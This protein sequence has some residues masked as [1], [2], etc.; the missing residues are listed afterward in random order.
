MSSRKETKVL[1]EG[2]RRF[3]NE[4]EEANQVVRIFDFDG[5]IFTP[6]DKF[7]LIKN[8]F[9]MGALKKDGINKLFTVVGSALG[10]SSRNPEY[11]SL[12]PSTDYIVSAVKSFGDK[13]FNAQYWHDLLINRN[14]IL[15]DFL[16]NY[17][18]VSEVGTLNDPASQEK[19]QEKVLKAVGKYFGKPDL[20]SVKTAKKS[21]IKKIVPEIPDD[22]IFVVSNTEEDSKSWLIK[23]L[24]DQHP[25]GTH[26]AIFDKTSGKG[27]DHEK[28]MS[29]LK[30][31]QAEKASGKKSEEE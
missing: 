30:V 3:I 14:N 29:A 2:W 23:K 8:A 17:L 1:F 21:F 22:H 31:A 4:A 10:E 28:M 18:D 20:D 9:Y 25:E 19:S 5:T 7:K 26:F 12:N 15:L 6:P 27:S 24:V 11:S 13:E 16:K